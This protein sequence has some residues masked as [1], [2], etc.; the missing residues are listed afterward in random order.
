MILA[1]EEALTVILV[2]DEVIL[3]LEILATFVVNNRST[4]GP[5]RA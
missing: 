2:L 4:I 5:V 3:G 1:P